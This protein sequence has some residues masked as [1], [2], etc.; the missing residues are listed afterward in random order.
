MFPNIEV[1][2]GRAIFLKKGMPLVLHFHY[3]NGG[4]KP[5]LVQDLARLRKV[6]P[7]EVE[8]WIAPM[9]L[10]SFDFSVDPFVETQ[11]G[12]DCTVPRDLDLI[13]VGGHMHALGTHF[14][15]SHIEPG[16]K[17]LS[18]IS[19]AWEPYYQWTPQ[20]R[21]RYDDPW[22]LAALSTLRVECTWHNSSA[23]PV[24]FPTEMC[25]AFGYVQD[26]TLT[27]ISAPGW[28]NRVFFCEGELK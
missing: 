4:T 5:I 16:L 6:D 13:L 12:F 3:A 22:R 19:E 27:Q 11:A 23:T 17:P 14:S 25:A 28:D 26:T 7:N 10:A 18:I 15:L 9:A 1:P 21:R 24:A 8:R 2:E 20:I